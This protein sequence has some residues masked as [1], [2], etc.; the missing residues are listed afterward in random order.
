[1]KDREQGIANQLAYHEVEWWKAHNEKDKERL[2]YHM[3]KLYELQF[4]ISFEQAGQAVMHRVE[5]AR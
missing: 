5:A 4:N 1:M 2:M 3:S